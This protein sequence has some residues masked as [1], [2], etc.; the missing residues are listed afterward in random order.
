MT[1]ANIAIRSGIG[2]VVGSAIG[3]AISPVT[4][5]VK[6]AGTVITNTNRRIARGAETGRLV[7]ETKDTVKRMNLQN[8][9]RRALIDF[10]TNKIEL[11]TKFNEFDEDMQETLKAW[12]QKLPDVI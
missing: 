1:L 3:K 12:E 7:S 10:G 4:S 5:A 8:E 11:D 9:Q 2:Y 6:G